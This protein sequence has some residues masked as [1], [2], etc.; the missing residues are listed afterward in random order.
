[1]GEA[2]FLLNDAIKSVTIQATLPETVAVATLNTLP[3]RQQSF[4]ETRY[5]LAIRQIFVVPGQYL[6][7]SDSSHFY[8]AGR[9]LW[10]LALQSLV[11]LW[12]GL[13]RTA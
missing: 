5:Y 13:R 7:E 2:R 10:R 1:M 12:I 8:L 6:F 4:V 3:R 9:L 11:C